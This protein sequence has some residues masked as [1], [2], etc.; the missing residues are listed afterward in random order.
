MVET[1]DSR[2]VLDANARTCRAFRARILGH[3]RRVGPNKW[4]PYRFVRAEGDQEIDVLPGLKI[5][6][7]EYGAVFRLSTRTTSFAST[8]PA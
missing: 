4:D 8:A 7:E 6:V 5:Q 3:F 2:D 1:I